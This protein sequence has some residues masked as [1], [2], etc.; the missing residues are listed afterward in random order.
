MLSPAHTFIE[1]GYIKS[2]AMP[3]D[4]NYRQSISFNGKGFLL[5]AYGKTGSC[6]V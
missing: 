1:G 2:C 4:R 6:P 5:K 3:Y